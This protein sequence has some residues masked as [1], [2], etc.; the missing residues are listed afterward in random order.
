[1]KTFED[2]CGVG[3][4]ITGD[5][6]RAAVAATVESIKAKVGDYLIF[7]SFLLSIIMSSSSVFLFDGNAVHVKLCWLSV[8][9]LCSL[10]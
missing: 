9:F 7:P 3:V 2:A 8:M 6:I 4:V 5:Q 1:M 10:Y